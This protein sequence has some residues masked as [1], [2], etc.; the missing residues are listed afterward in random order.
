M[1]IKITQPCEI[2]GKRFT[3]NQVVEGDEKT[4]RPLV[5][6]FATDDA[7][8]IAFAVETMHAKPIKLVSHETKSEAKPA[9]AAQTEGVK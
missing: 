3:P 6:A 5:P 4:L 9:A 8:S 1:K 7:D 2:A